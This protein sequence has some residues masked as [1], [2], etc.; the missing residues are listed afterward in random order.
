MTE[1]LGPPATPGDFVR[2]GG[3]HRVYTWRQRGAGRILAVGIGAGMLPMS[4]RQYALFLRFDEGGVLQHQEV[5]D[6]RPTGTI[7]ANPRDLVMCDTAATCIE[8]PAGR[9]PG[10]GLAI[11]MQD[12][13]SALTVPGD[14]DSTR[15]AADRCS[16]VL[17]LD[18]DDWTVP[19]KSARS[20]YDGS[21]GRYQSRLPP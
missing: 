5:V 15:P 1:L 3:Q 17:W 9:D 6:W 13:G 20:I 18:Q 19:G 10:T 12:S 2:P 11:L 7:D 21:A 4:D 14:P 16:L 8:H